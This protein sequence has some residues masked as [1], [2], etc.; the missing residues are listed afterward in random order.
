MLSQINRVVSTILSA[1]E[2][3]FII[4][5]KDDFPKPLLIDPAIYEESKFI[6]A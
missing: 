3:L 1:I 5:T 6:P 2:E 4:A